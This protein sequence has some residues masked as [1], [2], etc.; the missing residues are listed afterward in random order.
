MTHLRQLC[1]WFMLLLG[2]AAAGLCADP[3]STESETPLPVRVISQTVGSDELLLAIAAPEQIVA[4][5]HLARDSR[6]SAVAAEAEAYP[7]LSPDADAE[8]AVAMRPT[9]ILCA[10]YSRAELVSQVKKAG[11]RVLIFTKYAS[12]EDSYANLR[13]LA[14]EL[15]PEAEARAEKVIADCQARVASLQQRLQGVKPVRVMAPSVYGLI[16]GAKTTFQDLCDHAGAENLAASLGGLEGYKPPPGES[17][18]GW[19]VECVVVSGDSLEKAMASY[20]GI[21]PYKYMPAVREGRGVLVRGVILSCLSHRRV[22]GYEELARAL[23]PECFS[24]TP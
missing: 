9:L 20:Q 8:S 24:A 6:Y 12:L 13:L 19:P 18:L 14:R 1:R 21:A 22:D 2:V 3:S 10:D 11:V 15:G 16:P 5:S 4:L 7:Q 17:L 23:H